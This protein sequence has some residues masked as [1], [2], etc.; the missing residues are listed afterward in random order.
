MLK[1]IATKKNGETLMVVKGK[2]TALFAQKSGTKSDGGEWKRQDMTLTDASGKV[3]V[4]LWDR[5]PFGQDRIG[6]EVMFSST[7]NKHGWTG[8]KVK[9]N[10]FGGKTTNEVSVTGSAFIG[11]DDDEQP[12]AETPEESGP[13][14]E[15]P[16]PAPKAK[17]KPLTPESFIG[18]NVPY[19]CSP[20]PSKT[21]P[22]PASRENQLDDVRAEMEAF[23]R[24]YWLCY[25][26]GDEF[27]TKLA[28]KGKEMSVEHFQAMVSTA[29]IH[30]QKKGMV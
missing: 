6:H 4:K 2:V 10:D 17:A 19:D 3:N 29:F 28:A 30:L 13:E 7:K 20:K 11:W 27:V 1:E 18:D 9:A 23:N 24:T 14:E 5:E 22:W 15:A 26:A 8:V 12:A 21:E 16:A 25:M